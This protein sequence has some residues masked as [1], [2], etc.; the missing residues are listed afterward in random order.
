MPAY[1]NQYDATVLPFTQ[2]GTLDQ[3]DA[4][5][6]GQPENYVTGAPSYND[7]QDQFFL[8]LTPGTTLEFEFSWVTRDP[9]D[10]WIIEFVVFKPSGVQSYKWVRVVSDAAIQAR[11]T[12]YLRWLV[13]S[14]VDATTRM[15]LV[16]AG[17]VTPPKIDY[18]LT[19]RQVS[20]GPSSGARYGNF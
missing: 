18:T 6:T 5:Q 20:T 15:A 16:L 4:N 3:G 10:E 12:V 11:D 13:P 8:P 2:S 17:L 19:I 1:P 14:G 7:A 9:N